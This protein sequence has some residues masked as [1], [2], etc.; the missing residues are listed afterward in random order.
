MLRVLLLIQGCP[1]YISCNSKKGGPAVTLNTLTHNCAILILVNV[2][3]VHGD[4]IIIKLKRCNFRNIICL[5]Y[6]DQ[7][8]FCGVGDQE[9]LRT[10]I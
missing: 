3:D 2:N 1:V 5:P 10:K 6:Q 9:S 8:T 7:W 4:N